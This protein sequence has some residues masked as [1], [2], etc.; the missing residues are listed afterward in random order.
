MNN[1]WLSYLSHVLINKCLQLVKQHCPACTNG[2]K[3]PVL[4]YHM[5]LGLLDKMKCYFEE[6]RGSMITDIVKCFECFLNVYTIDDA[7][8]NNYVFIGQTFLLMSTAESVYYGRY[9]TEE[10]DGVLFPKPQPEALKIMNECYSSTIAQTS[11]SIPNKRKKIEK[12][13]TVLATAP[14]FSLSY[15]L[16]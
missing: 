1:I 2:L 5:Q 13:K 7:N 6:I 12:K 14:E 11:K 8:E 4:H 16:Q 9:I 15:D 3:S 10:T